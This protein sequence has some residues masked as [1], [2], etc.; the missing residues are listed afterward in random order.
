MKKLTLL[1]VL[2]A[3]VCIGGERIKVEI[4]KTVDGYPCKVINVDGC[5]YV[6]FKQSIIHH[7]CCTNHEPKV[8]YATNYI[9]NI[10]FPQIKPIQ[11]MLWYGTNYY[12]ITNGGIFMTN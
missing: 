4:A 9:Y 7:A 8:Q 5:Q 2:I 11:P 3:S 10:P 1:L 6:A 12:V